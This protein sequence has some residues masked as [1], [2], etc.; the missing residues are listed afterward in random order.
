MRVRITESDIRN[1]VLETVRILTEETNTEASTNLEFEIPYEEENQVNHFRAKL[2]QLKKKAISA[3]S[4]IN[5]T[6]TKVKAPVRKEVMQPNGSYKKITVLQDFAHF[7]ITPVTPDI[8]MEGYDYIGSIVPLSINIDGQEKESMIVSLANEFEGNDSLKKELQA[9]S[10]TMTCDGCHRETARGIYFCFLEKKTN[11]ILKLG[12]KCAAKYFG[13]NVGNK[14][15]SLFSALSSLGEEPYV[16]YDPDGFPAGKV[17]EPRLASLHEVMD[18]FE[19]EDFDKMVMRGCMAIAEYGPY[20]NMKN[21][22]THAKTLEDLIENAKNDC[23]TYERGRAHFDSGLFRI[24]MDELRQKHGELF[25]LREQAREL[26]NTFFTEGAKFFFYM[27]PQTEFEEKLK[28]IGLLVCGGSIQKKQIGKFNY[29]NFIPYCVAKFFKDKADKDPA[30]AER[31]KTPVEPFNGT[32]QFNVV[33][34]NID[35]KQ[36]RYGKDFYK[37]MATTDDNHTLTWNT[38]K[39]TP[40]FTRGDKIQITAEYNTQYNSLDNV[41][42]LKDT[43]DK[44][45][46][47]N[48]PEPQYPEDGHRYKNAEFNIIKLQPTYLVVKNTDDGCEYF[49]SNVA[50]AYGYYGVTREKFDLTNLSAGDN[51]TLTGTVSSYTSQRTGKTG[52]KLLRVKGLPPSGKTFDE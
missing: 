15:Q 25:Q 35:K 14:V 3:G 8:K 11:K 45:Q 24:Y 39:G 7:T 26:S 50:E 4:D 20:C 19:E 12:S 6:V 10:R 40:D 2:L 23:T 27:Q 29:L 21:S 43:A 51:I 28:N 30:N 33:I 42:I 44:P 48:T 36:T 32:K 52:H 5:F 38:F 1:I 16:I 49:I 17:R 13:I 31:Q 18:E 41:K 22:M 37:V 47:D 34:D 9:S 46:E